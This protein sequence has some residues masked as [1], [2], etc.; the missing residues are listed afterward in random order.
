MT[1]SRKQFKRS[2]GSV[3]LIPPQSL[4]EINPFETTIRHLGGLIAAY[5]VSGSSDQR[6]KAKAI[7]MGEV[8]YEAFAEN[9]M[10]CRTMVWPRLPGIKCDANSRASLA[11]LGSQSLEF[12]RLSI[13]SGNPKW[14]DKVAFLMG[15]MERTQS[16]S[17]VPGLWPSSID[18][19]CP[20]GLCEFTSRRY[21]IGSGAD[22]TYEYLPKVFPISP[23]FFSVASPLELTISV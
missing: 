7:E 22:S 14:A 11:R 5:D 2:T 18:Q 20:N 1:N 19:S 16:S 4:C 23:E 3:S 9:G 8:L 17:S 15:E 10:Q 12:I 13:I 6:L 21:S